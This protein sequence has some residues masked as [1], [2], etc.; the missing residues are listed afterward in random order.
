MPKETKSPS[1]NTKLIGVWGTLKRGQC[2]FRHFMS[3]AKFIGEDLLDGLG[4]DHTSVQ[5]AR[6]KDGLAKI[7]LFEVPEKDYQVIDQMEI[8][9]DYYGKLTKLESG[10]EVMIWFHRNQLKHEKNKE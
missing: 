5:I 7:E 9:Y 6:N 10:K 3:N 8:Y 1:T 4:D 2:N